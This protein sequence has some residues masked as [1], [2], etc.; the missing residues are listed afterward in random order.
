VKVNNR[1]QPGIVV[2]LVP[3]NEVLAGAARNMARIHG[4]YLGG[5]ETARRNPS[6]RNIIRIAGA[7]GVTVRER[8]PDWRQLCLSLRDP[9]VQRRAAPGSR[10][11]TMVYSFAQRARAAFL[12]IALR[13]DGVRT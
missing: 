10:K 9:T 8:F 4:R 13:W 2:A 12:A 5:I 11:C 3:A 6:L 1:N 7:L